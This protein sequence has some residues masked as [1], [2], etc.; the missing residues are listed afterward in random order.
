MILRLPIFKGFIIP[1]RFAFFLKSD[2]INFKKHLP[3]FDRFCI[4][5]FGFWEG[6]EPGATIRIIVNPMN[7]NNIRHFPA[8]FWFLASSLSRRHICIVCVS[9][10]LTL[11]CAALDHKL[12]PDLTQSRLGQLTKLSD[13]RVVSRCK[14]RYRFSVR[15]LDS[16]S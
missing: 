6:I 15:Y 14:L 5:G 12:H 4:E 3:V 9:L 1:M 13:P 7:D 16:T 10:T 11:H 2:C 8:S